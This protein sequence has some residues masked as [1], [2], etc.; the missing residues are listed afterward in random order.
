MVNLNSEKTN[1]IILGGG[2]PGIFSALYIAKK[3]PQYNV[4]LVESS[5]EIGGLY[6]SFKDKE[7]GIFDKGMHIIYETCIKEVD[8]IIRN[9]LPKN[10]WLFLEGNSKDIAG[11]YH[12]NVLE[13]NSPCKHRFY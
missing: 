2:I 9:C 12:N 4:H 10:E 11:V 3:N 1:I 13:K 8:E 7:A 6:N 5:E